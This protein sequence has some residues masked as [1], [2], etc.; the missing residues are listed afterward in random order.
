M[1]LTTLILGPLLMV[2]EFQNSPKAYPNN[3]G[4]TGGSVRTFS[5]IPNE[6]TTF[7]IQLM[8]NFFS[9]TPFINAQKQSRNQFRIDGNYTFKLGVP[10]EVFG[11]S[12]FTFNENSNSGGSTTMTT[13][14]E[15]V[16]LGLRFGKDLIH[17]RWYLGG[18]GYV[19][20][21]SGSQTGRNSSGASGTKSG[22]VLSGSA[23]FAST[24]DFT[25]KF[26]K[27]PL[28]HHLNVG[29]RLPNGDITGTTRDFDRFALDSFKYSAI[30]AATSFELIYKYVKPFIEY[31]MEYALSASTDNV[32]SSDNRSRITP[33]VRVTPIDAFSVLL[34]MDYSL[35][36]PPQNIQGGIPRNPPWD[37][38]V[39]LA[40]QTLGKKLGHSV[41]SM[42]GLVTDANSNL[43]L[44]DVQVAIVG[45]TLI[46]QNT[47]MAG[48][49]EF[50]DLPN[51]EYQA[52][53]EKLG[54]EPTT[55]SFSIRDGSNSV[56]D[57]SLG[58]AGPKMGSILA[59][60]VDA[61]TNEPVKRAFISVSGSDSNL[62]TDD[63][64]QVK[65]TSP[66]GKQSIHIEASGY[67]SQDF[68]VEVI[69]K[70]TIK[71]TLSLKKAPPLTGTCAGVVKN[72]DGTPLT[73]VISSADGSVAP[74]GTNPV[75]GEFA[76]TLPAGS[77][78]LKVQAEN[79]L[80]QEINCDVVAGEKTAMEL[81]LEKPKEA[82]VVDNK[83]ILPD[84]IYFEFNSAV[85][86]PESLPILD[87]VVKILS[88]RED[89]KVLNVE[90]HTDNVGGEAYN[91]KLSVRRAQSVRNYLTKQ[92]VKRDK[93]KAAGFGK[94][95]PIATNTTSEGRA[96]NRRVEF[97]LVRNE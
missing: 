1:L 58:V 21:F 36:G 9:D 46:P 52:R 35:S 73:A 20:A 14:F 88:T 81:T 5:A 39:G 92:G 67:T 42:R 19:R 48:F 87:Q 30:V 38:Y 3:I 91:Q 32:K 17:N 61:D 93:V 43:P 41:G 18:Y 83:I 50:Q 45:E 66:E 90:G 34:A 70:Q 37:M 97:N 31:S 24:L 53:F 23:G 49:Y 22:P 6:P 57:V 96:E 76:Q 44:S 12:S 74:F 77:H 56:V 63:A 8:G 29:Y 4:G 89:F 54:Y 85:I 84:A 59:T 47:D 40:F 79:Y 69:P 86:K 78:A 82:V 64:G 28:R 62:S 80:P 26:E 72:K 55:R 33:G 65:I 2:S 27:V 11:G 68:P 51:G 60:V 7:G 75:T 13:F 25:D 71:S 95:K 16:D 10:L 94:T 15:N